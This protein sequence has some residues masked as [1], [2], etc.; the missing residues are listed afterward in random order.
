M[1]RWITVCALTLVGL[2]GV[3]ASPAWADAPAGPQCH[4]RYCLDQRTPIEVHRERVTGWWPDRFRRANE[5]AARELGI[6]PRDV[7]WRNKECA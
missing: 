3:G 6:G 2:A 4:G 5:S 7:C 1:G